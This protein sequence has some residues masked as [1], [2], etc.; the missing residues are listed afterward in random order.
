M[1]ALYLFA[2]QQKELTDATAL[3]FTFDTLPQSWFP[4]LRRTGTEAGRY[5]NSNWAH[6]LL[7]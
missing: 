7:W 1:L 2:P 5:R 6:E 4:R 3:A